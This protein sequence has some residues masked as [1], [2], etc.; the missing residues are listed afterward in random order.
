MGAAFAARRAADRGLALS[1]RVALMRPVADAERSA[2][3]LRARGFAP[4]LAPVI[5]IVATGA[6]VP[7]DAFDAV[8]ATSANAFVFLSGEARVGLAKMK[9]FVAGE[10]TAAAANAAGWR[11]IN[12]AAVDARSLART[13]ADRGP[14]RFLY[15]AAPDRK[16][17][18]ESV[19]CAAG[20][21]VVTVEIYV[22]K[23]RPAW[24]PQE[25]RAFGSCAAAL[26]YS[27]RSA[28]LTASLAERA[29]LADHLRATLHVCISDDAAEPLRSIGARRIVVSA[30]AQEP[31][32]IDALSA[33]TQTP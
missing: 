4:V 17:D 8:I 19:L 5:D 31:L 15:L 26:H 22:A 13:L 3:L 9:L 16:S 12:E 6:D 11:G 25:A 14:S 33:A 28:E 2:A 21:Q 23:A 30:G 24:S 32:L 7:V 10:R 27:H 18:I 1:L 20:H 29:G